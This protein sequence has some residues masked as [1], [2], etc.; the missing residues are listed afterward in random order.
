MS[1]FPPINAAY[2]LIEEASNINRFLPVMLQGNNN[3]KNTNSSFRLSS[4]K[5]KGE[6]H[7]VDIHLTLSFI[8]VYL[9]ALER[10]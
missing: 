5:K 6:Y 2:M 7:K 8:C 10:V 9:Y 1:L 3:G 4:D